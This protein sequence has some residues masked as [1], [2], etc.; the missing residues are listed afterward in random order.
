ME[1]NRKTNIDT[2]MY[3]QKIF[4]KGARVIRKGVAFV[5]NGLCCNN[6]LFEGKKICDIYFSL[7]TKN[8]FKRT[9]HCIQKLTL[10]KPYT[11]VQVKIMQTMSLP[12][13]QHLT[14]N[15]RGNLLLAERREK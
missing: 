14:V 11:E 8:N 10:Q 1:S 5:F 13:Y 15:V 12:S 6:C 2:H 3:G 4:D 7:Y 9:I